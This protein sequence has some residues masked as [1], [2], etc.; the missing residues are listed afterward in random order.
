VNSM[1]FPVDPTYPG[2]PVDPGDHTPGAS[3]DPRGPG[4]PG[5]HCGDGGDDLVPPTF[6]EPPDGAGG[7]P[8]PDPRGNP[9]GLPPS[10]AGRFQPRER[11][12]RRTEQTVHRA[13]E[14]GRPAELRAAVFRVSGQDDATERIVKWYHPDAAPDPAVT[15][16]LLRGPLHEGLS[17]VLEAG[18]DRGAPYHVLP[19]HGSTDLA[20]HLRDRG[21]LP[22]DEIRRIVERLHGALTALH[23]AGIV[24]RDVKPSNLVLGDCTHLARGLVLIDF[25]ISVADFPRQM[26][27]GWAGTPGY[28]SPEAQVRVPIVR[29]ADDWWSLGIVVAEAALGRHPVPHHQPGSVMEAVQRGDIDLDGIRNRELRLLCEGLLTVRHE[30]RWGAEQVGQWLAGES[31]E[32]IREGPRPGTGERTAAAP[33]R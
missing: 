9:I 32:V 15:R 16:R 25:G 23:G 24:H 14:E 21:P 10:L 6:L 30:N 17:Y 1:A 22:A 5:G 18:R 11:L 4:G 20:T 28:V 19:S 13:A 2:D 26:T 12:P 8:A 31:P 33:G 27:G 7:M 3:D 29:P